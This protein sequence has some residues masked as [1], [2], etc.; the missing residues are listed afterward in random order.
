MRWTANSLSKIKGRVKNGSVLFITPQER[1]PI[2]SCQRAI[3][4]VQVKFNRKLWMPSDI[5]LG[6]NLLYLTKDFDRLLRIVRTSH[7]S[8]N[9]IRT[10][11]G[12]DGKDPRTTH[13][14]CGK[15]PQRLFFRGTIPDRPN[16]AIGA[17]DADSPGDSDSARGITK[18]RLGLGPLCY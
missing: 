12:T 3:G 18:N 4:T 1:R 9:E 15:C 7:V 17:R 11:R 14:D 13:P 6:K 10:K 8:L 16:P 2:F 5:R